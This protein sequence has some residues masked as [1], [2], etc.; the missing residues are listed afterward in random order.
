MQ[1]EIN[2]LKN[3]KEEIIDEPDRKIAKL[4]PKK[5]NNFKIN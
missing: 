2:Y 1:R 4:T 5:C 3:I